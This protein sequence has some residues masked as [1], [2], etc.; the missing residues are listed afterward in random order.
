MKGSS[1]KVSIGPRRAR[2]ASSGLMPGAGEWVRAGMSRVFVRGRLV[3]GGIVHGSGCPFQR[4]QAPE[5][6]TEHVAADVCLHA[7]RAVLRVRAGP[8]PYVRSTICVM[9]SP[10]VQVA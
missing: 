7:R 6:A 4:R 8:R 2:V 10:A 1:T 9:C 5:T 3:P